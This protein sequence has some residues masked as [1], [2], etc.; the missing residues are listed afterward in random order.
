MS[1][2][3]IVALK[4]E[5]PLLQNLQT[6]FYCGKSTLKLTI[7]LILVPCLRMAGAISPH[8]TRLHGMD[9]DNVTVTFTVTELAK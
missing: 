4:R 8:L 3:R 6:G 9:S 7:H 2:V 5:V 1:G